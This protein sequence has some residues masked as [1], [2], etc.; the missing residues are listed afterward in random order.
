MG[1]VANTILDQL[2]GRRFAMMTGAKNF[3]ALKND[4]GL[5]FQLPGGGGFTKNGIN[6]VKITLTPEDLYDVEYAKIRKGSYSVV[7]KSEGIYAEDLT[8]DFVENTGLHT[9]L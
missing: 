1:Q 2:G 3:T 4:S 8:D 5:Q 7:H 9:R 6:V